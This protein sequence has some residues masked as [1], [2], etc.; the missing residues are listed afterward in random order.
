MK[1]Q[2][3]DSPMGGLCWTSKSIRKIANELARQGIRIS[4]NCVAKLLKDMD[5]SLRMNRKWIESATKITAE[6]RDGQFQY[7]SNQR[8]EFADKGDPTISVDTKKKELI[9]NFKNNGRSWERTEVRVN[10]HDF[11][12][13]ADGLA[14]PYGV[15]DVRANTGCVT[16]GTSRDTA[17]LA[18]DAIETWWLREGKK[19]YSGARKLLILADCGGS[20]G[21]RLRAWKWRLQQQLCNR[22]RDLDPLPWV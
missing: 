16:V 1:H 22:L 9:G 14:V 10:D 12:S 13:Q 4:A 21:P 2:I 11:R 18:V 20:N 15:Y 3:A 6:D 19:H 5:F 8:E 17:A 7:I